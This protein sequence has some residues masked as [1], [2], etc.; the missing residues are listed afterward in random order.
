VPTSKQGIYYQDHQPGA[1]QAV[2]LLHG[3]G[4]HSDSWQLQFPALVEAGYRVIAPDTP[5][6]GKTPYASR[7]RRI[8]DVVEAYAEL[9]TSLGLAAVHVVGVS[10]GG[11]QALQ[12][13][14][15]HPQGVERLVLVNTFA[16]LRPR[17]SN[18]WAYFA[19]RVLLVGTLGL[20][21]QANFIAQR[22]FIKPDQEILRQLLVEEVC[23]ADRRG[24]RAAMLAIAR[25]DVRKRLGEIRCPTLVMTGDRDTTVDLVLQTSLAQTIPGARQVFLKDTGHAAPVESAEIFNAWLLDFLRGRKPDA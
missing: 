18:T 3:L 19:L 11:A 22:I 24:Y 25:Y 16:H 7:F 20:H 14:L 2:V 13:A 4:V 8:T 1:A 10:M 9:I 6:F 5:G 15:D 12:Y 17:A 23:Q 21:T